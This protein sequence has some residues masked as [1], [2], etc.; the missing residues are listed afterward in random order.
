MIVLNYANTVFVKFTL[1]YYINH[2]MFPSVCRQ[3]MSI[4]KVGYGTIQVKGILYA[5]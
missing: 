1:V 3:L 2:M 4:V 5:L